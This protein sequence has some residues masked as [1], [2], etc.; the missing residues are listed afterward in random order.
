L[1]SP[2]LAELSRW[3]RVATPVNSVFLFPDAGRDLYPGIFRTGALRAVYVDWK[4]GGQANYQEDVAAEWQRRWQTIRP[5]RYKPG[6]PRR[7]GGLGVDYVVLRNPNRS[8]VPPPA[9]ENS[10]YAVYRIH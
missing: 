9:F 3:A 7:Y 2:E 10:L 1:R 4:A 6:D 5:D 8:P